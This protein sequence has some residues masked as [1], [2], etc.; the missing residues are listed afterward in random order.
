MRLGVFGAVDYLVRAM[1][2]PVGDEPNL[3]KRSIVNVALIAINVVV[4]VFI[5]WPLQR[6]S[7]DLHDPVF[8]QYLQMLAERFPGA[9][10]GQLAREVSSFDL[11]VYSHG[12][13][14]SAPS[15]MTLF[16][17]MFMHASWMHLAGNMLFLWIYG[18]NVEH[19]LG[20]VGY[21]AT[22][23]V[24]GAAA[25]LFFAV[26]SRGSDVPLVGAS[27]AISGVLGLYFVWFPRNFVRVFVLF[28]FY[29][30]VWR[31]PARLVLGF[32]LFVDNLL[33]FLMDRGGMGVV[34]HGAHLGGFLTG[35]V[36]AWVLTALGDRTTALGL[37]RFGRAQRPEGIRFEPLGRRTPASAPRGPIA[38][39][40][41]LRAGEP[42]AALAMF[43]ELS[44]A[45][46]NQVGGPHLLALADWLTDHGSYDAALALLQ[47]FIAAHPESVDLGRAHLRAALVLM[48]FRQQPTAARE[49]LLQVLELHPTPELERVARE[50][51]ADIERARG[52]VLN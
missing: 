31:I 39:E 24:V 1:F 16:S 20:P 37:G 27:G 14:P 44:P 19:K 3:H 25:T 18:D 38:V 10:V 33:P 36:G 13:R 11:F 5:Q 29:F 21:V 8:L 22:Y 32:Y 45:E 7:P 23:L 6:Q 15:V 43:T 35:L 46:R 41:A 28:I 47:Q 26:F 51:L 50:A 52:G 48:H 42:E 40:Q 30:D 9:S 34:A 4:F 2:L 12:F 49:H 17:S